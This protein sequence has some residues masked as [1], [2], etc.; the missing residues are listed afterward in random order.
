MDVTPRRRFV[1]LDRDGTIN[2]EREYLSRVDQLEL[3]PRAAE[4][5]LA[6]RRLGYGLAV[7]TNQSGIARGYLTEQTLSRIHARLDEL[8]LWEG[9]LLDAY[10]H[11]PHLPDQG[12]ACRKPRPGLV[13]RAA[14][15]LAFDPAEC[16]VIGDKACDLE[17]GRA[18][19]AAT[20]LVRTGYGRQTELARQVDADFVV[21][22]LLHAARILEQMPTRRA[23]PLARA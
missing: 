16:V 15:E 10:Y 2:V 7:I 19:G 22:D 4:G 18:I 11:C 3:V 23:T 21:D 8:L 1:L 5:L 12:C 13:E 6:M 9:A 17:L 14:A 20:M